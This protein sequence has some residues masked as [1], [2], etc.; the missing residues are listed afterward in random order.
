M[1]RTFRTLSEPLWEFSDQHQDALSRFAPSFE[2]KGDQRAPRKR[3]GARCNLI[4]QG[5]L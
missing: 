4:Q 1:E 5:L 3:W 2:G